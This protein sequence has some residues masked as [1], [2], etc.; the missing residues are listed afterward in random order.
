MSG[1][2]AMDRRTLMLQGPIVPTVLKLAAPNALAIGMQIAVGTAETWYVGR[3]GTSALAGVALVFPL[4]TLMQMMSAG[5]MGGGI[6]SAIARALGA[7]QRDEAKSIAWHAMAIEAGIGLVFML[8]A[9]LFGTQLYHAMG[10]QGAALEAALEYSDVLF[11]GSLFMW[12]MNGLASVMRGSGDMR[13]PA[14]TFTVCGLI[15]IGLSPLMIFGFGPLAFG[16]LR[17]WQGWGIRGAALAMT[18]YYLVGTIILALR[19][20]RDPHALPIRPSPLQR[21]HLLGIFAVGALAS[22]HATTVNII[23]SITTS[24][25]GRH[26]TAAIAGYGIGAR[27]EALQVPIA[28][29]FGAA[30]V[31]MVGTNIGA[32]QHERARRIAWAGA[33]M[34]GGISAVIGLVCAIWP[35]GWSGLFSTDPEVLAASATYFHVVGPAYICIGFGMA[36]YFSFQGSGDM[37]WPVTCVATRV[38]IVAG[39]C[40]L[41]TAF[42]DASL[43]L[44]FMNNTIAL[45]VFGGMYVW[46][47]QHRMA[48]PRKA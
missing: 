34:A 23:M 10:G 9:L 44:L 22:V 15:A 12:I 24:Y 48:R 16:P 7:G 25:V 42:T 1:A 31:A 41:V 35:Q 8:L 2:T 4:F 21:K 28:F 45:L 39:G 40:A 11:A 18:G 33:L 38:V 47:M 37:R 32:G 26:G 3:L 20:R 36:T 6:S 19:Y 30:L 17:E 27:L 43:A 46:G 13:T 29:T 5:A 14:L